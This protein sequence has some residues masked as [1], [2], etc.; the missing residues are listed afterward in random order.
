MSLYR[1]SVHGSL[2]YG[3]GQR[4]SVTRFTEKLKRKCF[5]SCLIIRTLGRWESV[6]PLLGSNV[7]GLSQK[8]LILWFYFFE[9][10]ARKMHFWPTK[11]STRKIF[12]LPPSK[13]PKKIAAKMKY[14][15]NS[16]VPL[17]VWT[18]GPRF[19]KFLVNVYVY[20]TSTGHLIQSHAVLWDPIPRFRHC[21]QPFTLT[22]ALRRSRPVSFHK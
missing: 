11:F 12:W 2:T 4:V 5:N 8:I 13:S 16:R 20:Q 1:V 14:P 17:R 21:C 7:L 9:F 15:F 3:A 6:P 10:W 22:L 18:Q 19:P